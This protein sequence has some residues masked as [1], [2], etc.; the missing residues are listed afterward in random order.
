M[1]E[2]RKKRE[3]SLSGVGDIRRDCVIRLW[4]GLAVG[5]DGAT[6]VITAITTLI[7]RSFKCP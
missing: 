7:G 4:A 6:R 5:E 2:E 1:S 3:A